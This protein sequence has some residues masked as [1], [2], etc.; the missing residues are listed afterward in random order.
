VALTKGGPGAPSVIG[1]RNGR[2]ETHGEGRIGSPP[3][4]GGNVIALGQ[5][6]YA[7]EL[8]DE[9][10]QSGVV[11]LQP[12]GRIEGTLKIGG[13][14]AS[15]NSLLFTLQ[16]VGIVTDFEKF[17]VETDGQGKFQFEQVPAGEGQIVR[18]IKMREGAWMHS[19]NTTANVEPGKTTVVNLGDNGALIRSRARV[20]SITNADNEP[21]TISGNLNMKM[22]QMPSFGTPAEYRVY[23]QT[24]EYK[25]RMAQYKYFGVT[26]NPDGSFQVDSVPSGEYKLMLSAY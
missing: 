3:E 25:A 4:S 15:G 14:R 6:G 1:W 13:Q 2:L 11:V 7:S 12:F 9:L 8:V 20:G 23:Q 24:P 5:Q 22:E 17:K 16:N 19:H 26:V 18:L 10:R 21:L